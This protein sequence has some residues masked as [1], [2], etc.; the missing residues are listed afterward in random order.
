M[1][2]YYILIT[3]AGAALESA[4]HANGTTVALAKFG[5]CDGGVDFTPDPTLTTFANEV[6]NGPISS[7]AVSTDDP[8]V[9][10]AQCVIPST[11]GGYTIRGIALYASD[12]TLY[13][14]G[15]YPD[16]QKPATDSGYS[17]SL[18]ILAQL[19]VSDTA[20]ITL[21][22]VDGSY[23][24]ETEA[25]SLYLRQDKNLGE[26]AAAGV[27]AQSASRGNLGLGD[28]ATKNTGTTAGT[29]A[30]GDD[31]RITGA[32]Q[33]DGSNKMKGNLTLASTS[34]TQNISSYF[35]ME[36]K[37][38]WYLRL[39]LW[40]S[41]GGTDFEWSVSA[42]NDELGS[43]I[44]MIGVDND[45]AT[46]SSSTTTGG[47]KF[48]AH[49]AVDM[50][51][52]SYLDAR[53][54]NTLSAAAN[55]WE[56]NTSNGKI[57]Q[58]G[59]PDV[60]ANN[61]T[62]PFP[63]A[64]PSTPYW[65]MIADAENDNGQS[66]I[67]TVMWIKDTTTSTALG[68]DGL[69]GSEEPG[70]FSWQARGGGT[71]S[72]AQSLLSAPE[73]LDH[74]GYY[75]SAT[76]NAFYPAALYLDYLVF[77]TWPTDAAPVDDSVY[78][79]FAANAAPAGKTRAAGDDGLPCWIDTPAPTQEQ[80][81]VSNTRYRQKLVNA[82]LAAIGV[83]QSSAAAGKPRDGDADKLLELQQYVDELR[84]VNPNTSPMALPPQPASLN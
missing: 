72:S 68:Y 23:L 54:K 29:V 49:G 4:A 35:D 43:S 69:G 19:A 64:F 75:Y 22:V 46:A 11:S 56:K 57:E 45:T 24:T 52:W 28:S 30:A 39:G 25:D 26:I 61:G 10:V 60:S 80:I 58:W 5:V 67:T 16:Q 17:A 50:D 9:L 55:G 15:N 41:D 65:A 82:A 62:I 1:S 71:S 8:A 34:D 20:D 6:Y 53:Y 36:M 27:D 40:G 78:S 63:I 47:S 73:P 84:D 44:L 18:E 70:I 76:N 14:T 83:L 21:Q 13:A 37:D 12:G 48:F 59:V 42:H 77:G 38:G 32:L 66:T 51:D 79:E 33:T 74:D 7:L 31:I 3:D 2:D 81:V